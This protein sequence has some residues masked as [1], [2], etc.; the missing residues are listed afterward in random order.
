[1]GRHRSVAFAEELGRSIDSEGREG[2]PVEVSHRDLGN[3]RGG[4]ASGAGKES[5]SRWTRKRGKEE[6][7]VES[8]VGADD[9]DSKICPGEKKE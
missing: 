3:K 6:V 2:W 9:G 5:G 4:R 1:M 7:G 8:D